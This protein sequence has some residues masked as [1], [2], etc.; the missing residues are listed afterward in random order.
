MKKS[1]QAACQELGGEQSVPFTEL[2]GLSN[3]IAS[4]S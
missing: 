1:V 3:T 2:T 4:A